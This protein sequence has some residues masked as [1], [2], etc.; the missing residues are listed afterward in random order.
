MEI[1]D[2]IDKRARPM[3]SVNNG[4]RRYM[5]LASEQSETLS[6]VPIEVGAVYV[7]MYMYTQL[8]G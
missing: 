8:D 3:S 1:G 7:R 5:L 6:G 4:N 2:I